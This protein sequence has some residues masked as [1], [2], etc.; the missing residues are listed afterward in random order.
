MNYLAHFVFNHDVCGLAARPA[1]VIGVALPDLWPRFS[2]KRRLKWPAV[3]A[4][5]PT[6]PTARDLQA[7]LLNHVEADRRFHV[8]PCFLE[9][10]RELKRRREG[11]GLHPWVLDFVAHVTIELMLDH[12]LLRDEPGLA[13]RFYDTIEPID[14]AQTAAHAG[15]I[16][17]VDCT[18]LDETLRLF[19]ARRYMRRYATRDGI[20]HALGLIIGGANLR[21]PPSESS[22]C[23]LLDAAKRIVTPERVWTEL[24]R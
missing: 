13:D 6:D 16:G 9:W 2:R 7:G 8:L 15:V 20:M 10:L 14:P 5:T 21:A 19:M 23:A 12:A 18:G 3:R 24:S 17:D 1:F 11:D 22:V 4:A